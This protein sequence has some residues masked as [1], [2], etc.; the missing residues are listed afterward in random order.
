MMTRTT[1][2]TLCLTVMLSFAA[3]QQKQ[4]S[5]TAATPAPAASAVTAQT[6]LTPEQLG[7]LGGLIKNNPDRA[8]ELLAQHNMTRESFEK[9][10]RDVTENVDAS[11]RYAAAYR[12]TVA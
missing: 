1:T 4:Q 10:I 12:K 5:A 9:A 6:M 3:C 2:A 8:N 11:K 7:E